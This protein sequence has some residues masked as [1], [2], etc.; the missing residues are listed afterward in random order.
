MSRQRRIKLDYRGPQT[1][2]I[3]IWLDEAE[4]IMNARVDVDRLVALSDQAARDLD[5]F[6]SAIIDPVECLNPDPAAER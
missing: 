5:T 4:A 6:G 1:P 3:R 2:E